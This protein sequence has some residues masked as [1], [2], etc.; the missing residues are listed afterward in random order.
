MRETAGS[1]AA[2]AARCRNR[3][4]RSLVAF[5][6]DGWPCSIAASTGRRCVRRVFETVDRV[7]ALLFRLLLM[8]TSPSLV[9]LVALQEKVHRLSVC[10]KSAGGAP[11][12]CDCRNCVPRFRSPGSSVTCPLRPDQWQN[13]SKACARPDCN[14]AIKPGH[15]E[16][17]QCPVPA[18]RRARLVIG[19]PSV[20]GREMGHGSAHFTRPSQRGTDGAGWR[21]PGIARL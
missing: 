10:R 13:F 2:P 3:R 20:R 11:P 16:D 9:P 14:R 6:P 7:S 5:T 21:A 8:P 12:W 1:A 15:G 17:P 18:G 19:G 4:R